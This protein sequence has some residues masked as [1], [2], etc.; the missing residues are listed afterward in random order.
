MILKGL[1][2]AWYVNAAPYSG[3]IFWR[4]KVSISL[5]E[6][7]KSF[8]LRYWVPRLLTA[9]TSRASRYRYTLPTSVV[10]QAVTTISVM[11]ALVHVY[12][13]RRLKI[14]PRD[15]KREREMAYICNHALSPYTRRGEFDNSK[16]NAQEKEIHI[17]FLQTKMRRSHNTTIEKSKKI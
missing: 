3:T 12:S 14:E 4:L 7:M 11:C 15:Y 1:V 16:P 8:Q 9:C 5:N 10:V 13:A 2:H 17:V 6:W